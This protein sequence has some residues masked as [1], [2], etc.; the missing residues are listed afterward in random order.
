M[1]QVFR[2]NYDLQK[3]F[4]KALFS[5]MLNISVKCVKFNHSNS[6]GT[7]R[8]ATRGVIIRIITYPNL[9]TVLLMIDN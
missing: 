7:V 8:G 2:N 1:S 5:Y 3:Y 4:N 6:K 9:F